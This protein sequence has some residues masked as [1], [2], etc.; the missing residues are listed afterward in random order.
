MNSYRCFTKLLFQL[1]LWKSVF[2]LIFSRETEVIVPGW[3]HVYGPLKVSFFLVQGIA[4]LSQSQYFAR[5][6]PRV[7]K[8][9]DVGCLSMRLAD[10]GVYQIR[11]YS[12]SG[13]ATVPFLHSYP[14]FRFI[15]AHNKQIILFLP[16]VFK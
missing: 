2:A 1:K 4:T 15:E 5:R 12:R 8:G 16:S 7:T 10:V 13:S 3:F 6:S 14:S 11:F 9:V